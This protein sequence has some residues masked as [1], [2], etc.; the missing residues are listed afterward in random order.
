M[1]GD[2]GER[3]TEH[4]RHVLDEACFPTT[5]RPVQYHREPLP[6]GRGKDFDFIA[7]CE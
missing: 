2:A 3:Q 7:G 5:G 6:V 4:V 1:T